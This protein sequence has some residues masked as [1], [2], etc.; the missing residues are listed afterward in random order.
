[1]RP[2]RPALSTRATAI[3]LAFAAAAL[4]A[5]GCSTTGDDPDERADNTDQQ[6]VETSPGQA[7]AEPD[8]P[9]SPAQEQGRELFV[10]GCGSCHTLEAAGTTGQVGPNLDELD[11][12]LAQV[13]RAI[14]VG[15]RG[16]GS[17]P[18]DIYRGRQ[19][20]IVARFVA[21]NDSGGG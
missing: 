19:A 20:Q 13:L 8:Q 1:M 11:P 14:D 16:S 6:T 4:A 15:G 2:R 3:A 10:S 17:M 5:G 7:E 9:L 12:E 18:P 21:E